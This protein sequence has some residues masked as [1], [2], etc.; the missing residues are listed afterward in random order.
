[1]PEDLKS[2]Q[3]KAKRLYKDSVYLHDGLATAAD[4]EARRIAAGQILDNF[5]TL[6]GWWEKLDKWAKTGE[7]P[8][9]ET[10]NISVD[11]V[12]ADEANL[13]RRITNLKTYIAK[14]KDRTDDKG[15]AKLAAYQD[16]HDRIK[17]TLD[18]F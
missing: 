8:A 4:T 13:L 16:E 9:P 2:L 17:K 15:K 3:D 6:S 14:L 10:D 18:A 7:M 1:M 11:L 5:K 12:S